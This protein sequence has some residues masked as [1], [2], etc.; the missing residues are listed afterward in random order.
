LEAL[1]DQLEFTHLKQ[2]YPKTLLTP[3]KF[4]R[5]NLASINQLLQSAEELQN[6][7]APPTS[8]PPLA[9]PVALPLLAL[10]RQ[11][12]TPNS[13]V[14]RHALRLSLGL[15]VGYGILQAFHLDKGFWILLTVLFVCQPSYSATRRRLVQRMLGTFAGILIGVPVLWFF[16][17]LH[18]QLGIMGLAAFLFFTQV[19]SNYSA[20]VCFITLYVLMAFN[21]LDGIGFAILGP[22]LLD[23]LLGCLLSYALVAWLWPDWQYKRLPTLIA[24]SL[25]AN[26]KYLSAV[27]A[28]LHRQ[29]D[30][31]LD[32]RVARKCAHLADSE[33]AMAW[34]S[35]LV[36]PS[37]RRRFLDLCFT[38]T[39]RNHALLSY[40]SALGAHR[41]KLEPIEGLEEISRHISQT[42]EQA[43]G[44]L[45]G[46][47]PTPLAGAC[48]AIAPE[49]SEEQLM[50]S[51]QLS[52]ISQLA[53]ELLVLAN[54]GQLLTGQ[55]RT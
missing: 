17:E 8:L 34:Q 50:L 52:L 19:R 30:E 24:N 10:L 41:D 12:L 40:I 18:L 53:D 26:A 5:R 32:Y 49:S 37:K 55:G 38:L 31:S 25:S 51:Q 42:L 47:M 13:M 36:E 16:P 6:P 54:D 20:A 29:R 43:A 28:S 3:M 9:R 27:L 21:L 46:Q 39:W 23:T 35:M 2:H 4:L 45:A 48:P 7:A 11:H 1:G 44:H 15:V 22:R 14:F 33:L